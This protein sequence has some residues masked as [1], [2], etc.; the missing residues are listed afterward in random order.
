MNWFGSPQII[1][2]NGIVTRWWKHCW[3]VKGN[4][5]I[6]NNIMMSLHCRNTYSISRIPNLYGMV[7]RHRKYYIMTRE[8]CCDFLLMIRTNQLNFSS[9]KVITINVRIIGGSPE[10]IVMNCTGVDFISVP[11]VSFNAVPGEIPQFASHV[12]RTWNDMRGLRQWCGMMEKNFWYSSGMAGKDS[13]GRCVIVWER[14]LMDC[15]K[16]D[17]YH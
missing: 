6:R 12:L 4:L 13:S 9:F 15:E 10:F 16:E 1:L 7:L 3:A 2:C 14:L 5:D 17:K 8:N 11:N